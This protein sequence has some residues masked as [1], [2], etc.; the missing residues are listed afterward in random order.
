[1][2]NVEADRGRIEGF[3]DKLLLMYNNESRK[4]LPSQ[5][6]TGAAMAAGMQLLENQGGRV[7]VFSSSLCSQG[8]GILQSRNDS[9]IYN[10]DSEKE[11]YNHTTQ[12]TFFTD[13][14]TSALQQNVTFD[15]YFGVNSGSESIDL[16]SISQ[17]AKLT[18]GDVLYL[19][20]FN[21][22][23][24]GEKLYFELF[25]NLT[26]PIG[27]DVKIRARCSEGFTVTHYFGGFGKKEA[28]DFEISSIDGDKT[29]CFELRNDR[30]VEVKETVHVQIAVLFTNIY[31]ERRVRVFN[32]A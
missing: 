30:T 7:A 1:M 32:I 6:C 8:V 31:G 14:A 25:R 23:R 9:K 22:A 21:P 10:T 27:S 13:L 28:I 3:L 19:Y 24:N 5:S 29:F 2:L 12:H 26:K 18:G 4:N 16:A 20:K 17:A 11:L 15:L